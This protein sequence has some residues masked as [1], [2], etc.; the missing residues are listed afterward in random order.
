MCKWLS[1]SLMTWGT[2]N[3]CIRWKREKFDKEMCNDLE[4][5]QSGLQAL[6]TAV[7]ISEN[8]HSILCIIDC[9]RSL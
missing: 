6:S 7:T 2:S 8:S 3:N 9:S 1:D 4:E 5:R